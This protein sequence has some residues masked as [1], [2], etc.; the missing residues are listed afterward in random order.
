M[1]GDE[2]FRVTARKDEWGE[3]ANASNGETGWICNECRFEKKETKDWVIE[4]PTMINRSSVIAQGHYQGKVGMAKQ[5]ELI[6]KVIG[7]APK[8]TLD[9]HDVSEVNKPQIH[10]SEIEGPAHSDDFK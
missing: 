10:L 4:G 8:L 5:P 9:I 3:I 7:K 2:V 1:R 6:E